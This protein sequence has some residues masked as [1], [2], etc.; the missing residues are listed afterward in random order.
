MRIEPLPDSALQVVGGVDASFSEDGIYVAAVVL[1]YHTMQIVELA[2]AELSLTYPYLPGLLSFRESPAILVA[3]G[4]LS[5]LPDVL[6]VDGHGLAHPRRFGLACHLGVL[7]DLPVIGCAKS[8]LIG[9]CSPP[10]DTVGSTTE[11]IFEAEMVGM[12]VRT[13]SNVKPVYVSVGHRVDL[14]SAVRITLACCRG[15]R[16]PEPT[17]QAHILARRKH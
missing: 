1:D 12:A 6:L 4:K 9:E 8:K 11:L 14:R 16:L 2:T 10:G 7:L 13:R 15:Y 3:L 5:R 17:R